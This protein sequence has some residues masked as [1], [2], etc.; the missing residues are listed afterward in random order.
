[1]CLIG[2]LATRSQLTSS[3]CWE[4]AGYGSWA[5]D[6]AGKNRF[7]GVVCSQVLEPLETSNPSESHQM[8]Q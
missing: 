2:R 8:P 7:L 5:T 3:P 6:N 4:A 1:M